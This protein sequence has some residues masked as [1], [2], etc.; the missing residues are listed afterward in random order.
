VPAEVTV[1][2]GTFL[3]KPLDLESSLNSLKDLESVLVSI[4]IIGKFYILFVVDDVIMGEVF[5]MLVDVIGRQISVQ[6]ITA[7]C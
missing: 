1:V 3:A 4:K 7:N 2:Q 6:I 5:A